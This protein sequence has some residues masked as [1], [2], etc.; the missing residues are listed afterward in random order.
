MKF[1]ISTKGFT[2]IIN[3]TK[4]I[5]KE[6]KIS[7]IKDGF[8]LISCPGSTI[9]LTTIEYEEGALNDL[10]RI[11]DKLVPGHQ[12]LRTLQEMGGL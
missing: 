10:K 9:G 1:Q 8:C 6:V 2:D 5:L 7:G 11:L 4:E 3:I 12:R